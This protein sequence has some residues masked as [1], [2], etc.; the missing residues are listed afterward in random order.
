MWVQLSLYYTTV[1]NS[2]VMPK[3]I[4]LC[5]RIACMYNFMGK[6]KQCFLKAEKMSSKDILKNE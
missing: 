6:R 3:Y 2:Y 1:Y 5:T 4:H